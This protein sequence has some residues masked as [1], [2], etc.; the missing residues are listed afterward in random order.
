MKNLS[1]LAPAY[2]TNFRLS[3]STRFWWRILPSLVAVLLVVSLLQSGFYEPL[4]NLAYSALF[5]W[6]GTLPWG[7]Q[8]VVVEID[9]KSLSQL[10]QLP[11]SRQHYANFIDRLSVAEPSAIVLDLLLI[12]PSSADQ[13]LAAAMKQQGRVVLAQTWDEFGNPIAP[14]PVLADAA[15]A[16][17]HIYRQ[18]DAD[19]ITRAIETQKWEVP[20]LGVVAA[21]LHRSFNSSSF[22]S[23]LSLADHLWLNWLAPAREAPHYSFLS[24]LQGQV[25]PQVFRNKVVLVGVTA[26]GTDSINTPFDRNPSSSGVYLQATLTSNLLQQNLLRRPDQQRFWLAL[27][28]GVSAVSVV[29]SRWQFEPQLA[30]WFGCALGWGFLSLG[31]LHNEYWIPTAAPMLLF[32][33]IGGAVALAE[34]IHTNMLLRQSEERYALAVHGANEGL[35]DWDLRA[36]RIYFSSRWQ[37]MIGHTEEISDRPREWFGR[38]HPEDLVLLKAAIDDHLQGVTDHFEHEHRMIH[39]DGTY[40]WMLSRGLA[41]RDREGKAERMVGS[42]TDITKRKRAEEQLR[43]SAFFDGLTGLPNR[44]GFLEHLQQAM[45]RIQKYP[46]TAFAVFWLDL[47]QFKVVNNSL[48]SEL[49]DRLLVAIAQRLKAFLVGEDIIARVGGDEFTILLNQIQDVRD[50]TRMAERVQQ[51]LALPFNLDG[52]EVFAT[53]SIGIALSSTRYTEPE[54]L[55]RDADTAMHRAK[56]LGRARY[57]V[58][59]QAMHTRMLVRLQLENDLRRAIAVGEQELTLAHR[60][61]SIFQEL[62]LYYQ[63]IVCLGTGEVRGFEALVRW[64]HPE[65]GFLLPGKFIAMAE[66]TGLIVQMGWWILRQACQQMRQWR[67]QFPHQPPLVMSVNLS[68][69]QFSQSGLIEQIRQILEETDLDPASLKLEMTESTVMENAASVVNMLW[70]IRGLGIQL[71]ID[72]FGTGYSSLSY[73]RRFPINTLKIDRS[74]VS[75]MGIANDDCAEIVR[76]ILLLAHNLGLDVT[77]EGVETQDQADQLLNM[78]CEYGQGY[79]FSKP[80]NAEAAT[81]LLEQ[82]VRERQD[83]RV[84]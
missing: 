78:R 13:Q 56:L 59:D 38:V 71:A 66:E 58:F 65:R 41:V 83:G 36:N 47:D 63:P 15:I 1:K 26:V 7:D 31:L 5:S 4:E 21:Q 3:S 84:N 77:A 37:A 57:Q 70:Q 34:Q 76:T 14:N 43:H 20:A 28:I 33:L 81:R 29:V 24:V 61:E 8:V 30:V 74:F 55:L 49:G 53:V 52:R 22:R 18:A 73:L 32:G 23:S 51:V 10:G 40:R 44:A 80:L 35:W 9:E 64:Q 39:Q 60:S 67:S 69:K 19:G 11:W 12:E 42:Q 25:P 50:A 62:Q 48:G 82:G 72:D 68:G 79:F 2:R 45:S 46:M 6:R 17:G 75:K 27:F 54:H 16:V